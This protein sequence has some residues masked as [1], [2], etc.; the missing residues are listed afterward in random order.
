MVCIPPKLP[1]LFSSMAFRTM[2]DR[3]LSHCVVD[4]VVFWL[5]L[6]FRRMQELQHGARCG[7]AWGAAWRAVGFVNALHFG[8][9]VILSL[10]ARAAACA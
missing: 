4:C 1:N 5:L 10:Q 3:Y 7:R 2:L 9:P 6:A 8:L